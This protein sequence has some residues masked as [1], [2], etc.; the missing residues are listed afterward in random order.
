MPSAWLSHLR[1]IP[2]SLHPVTGKSSLE[3]VLT[4]LH[5]GGKFGG[6]SSG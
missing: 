4:E 3:T 6:E 2:T 1:G 5:A